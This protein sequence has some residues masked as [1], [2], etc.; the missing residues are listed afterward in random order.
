MINHSRPNALFGILALLYACSSETPQIQQSSASAAG[1]GSGSAANG[2]DGAG[3]MGA[4][5]TCGNGV[6]DDGEECDGEPGCNA[7]C[8]WMVDTDGDGISDTD[9]GKAQDLDTDNDG[10]PDYLDSDSDDDGIPDSVEAGDSDITTPPVNTDG[11]GGADFQD[12]D[13][14]D[15]GLLDTAEAGPDPT[16]PI[17]TDGDFVP[18]YIDT[19]SDN[20]DLTDAEEYAF[21]T[22]HL[23]P[24]TDGDTIGDGDEGTSDADG[25]LVINALDDDSDQD[26]HLDSDEAGDT[27]WQTLPVDTDLDGIPDYLDL[28]SDQDGLPDLQE[29]DCPFLGEHGR[30]WPDTDFDGQPD[31]AEVIAGSDPCDPLIGVE[32]VGVEFFFILP[33]LDPEKSDVLRFEPAVK[34]A[35]V[36]FNVDTTGSMGGEIANLK[37]GMSTIITETELRVSDAGFGVGAFDDFPVSPFGDI[38]SGDVPFRLLSGITINTASATAAVNA[39]NLHFG[40]DFPES[41][42]ESLYQVAIG[43]GVMGAAGNFGPFTKAGA[44]GGAQFRI[45]AL[46]IVLHITDALSHDASCPPT[47]GI[48]GGWVTDYPANFMD[49]DRTQALAGL[50]GIG[51]RVITVQ[52]LYSGITDAAS[53]NATIKGVMQDISS[54]TK[55]T[56]PTCAFKTSATTWRC[57]VGI[58]CDGTIPAGTECI[59]R[60]TVADDGS[61]LTTAA[62]DGIDAII[63]YSKFNVFGEPRDDGTANTPDT[64]LFLTKIEAITPDDTFKP[65]LEPERSCTPVPTPAM[66]DG[67]VNY[68]NGF[69]GYAPGTS[70]I[71]VEGA[72]LFFTVTAENTFVQETKAPQIFVAYIDIVDDTTATIL[73]TQDVLIIVPAAP[74]GA[75]D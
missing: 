8:T 37:S 43:D 36:F 28:D 45:G 16:N 55:A 38:F 59:L 20:D 64:S 57:G 52:S 34:K 50:Q 46:P 31:L 13:A 41:G 30:Y 56:V 66:L 18:D 68:N 62:V 10:T 47:M 2:S 53:V 27:N 74:G 48:Y 35:D 12:T 65:A 69:E 25:D 71:G 11:T 67:Q 5:P 19:D 17:D 4:G 26:G 54:N 21:G 61:G 9:E 44:I 75:G 22:N 14:D 24:D 60:Y 58:C 1:G 63:K 39:L 32:D 70:L 40:N 29:V 23:L 49:H 73:D 7:N 42:W 51:A 15:D 33:H 3:A 6:L 72:K